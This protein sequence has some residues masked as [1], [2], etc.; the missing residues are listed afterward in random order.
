[1]HRIERVADGRRFDRWDI[2][3]NQRSLA[4][5]VDVQ[6]LDLAGDFF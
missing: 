2:L 3:T 1:M 6:V 4:V 5:V